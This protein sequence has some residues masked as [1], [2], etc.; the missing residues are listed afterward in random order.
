MCGNKLR[1]VSQ[2]IKFEKRLRINR[3]L[4]LV[5][6]ELFTNIQVEKLNQNPNEAFEASKR[7][8]FEIQAFECLTHHYKIFTLDSKSRLRLFSTSYQDF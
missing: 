8:G 2:H 7:I 5:L 4:N 6:N 3:I 1:I